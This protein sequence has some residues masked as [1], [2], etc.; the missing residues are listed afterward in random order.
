MW[1]ALQPRQL[2]TEARF[3]ACNPNNQSPIIAAVATN[4]HVQIMRLRGSRS[5]HLAPCTQ[6]RSSMNRP[7][8]P[9]RR[10]FFLWRTFTF[11]LVWVKPSTEILTF[12][13]CNLCNLHIIVDTS[14]PRGFSRTGFHVKILCLFCV[15]YYFSLTLVIS[16]QLFSHLWWRSIVRSFVAKNL[17]SHLEGGWIGDMAN[18]WT[19]CGI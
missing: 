12:N 11:S 15:V 8:R 5:Y 16:T 2:W 4:L 9:T 3:S 6:I 17:K 19:K 1:N 18:L 10:V 13:P 14:P 7:S